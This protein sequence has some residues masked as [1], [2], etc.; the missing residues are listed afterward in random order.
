MKSVEIRKAHP[1]DVA[2][3]EDMHRHC[4][5]QSLYLRYLRTR[6]PSRDELEEICYLSPNQGAAFVA[7]TTKPYEMIVGLA[8]YMRDG[9]G[10]AEPAV[11]VED[12]YQGQGIG[13]DLLRT[14]TLHA[15]SQGVNSYRAFV[16]GDNRGMIGIISRSGLPYQSEYEHGTVEFR[17]GI[18]A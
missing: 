8:Y 17:I 6:R 16:E 5:D 13:K 15:R 10:C 12:K 18:E 11:L 3:L 2:M 7:V 9:N 4:S 14:L 1:R